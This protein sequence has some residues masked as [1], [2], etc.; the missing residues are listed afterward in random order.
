MPDAETRVGELSIEAIA[1]YQWHPWQAGF[2]LQPWVTVARPLARSADPV[3]GDHAYQA[4]FLQL[5]ATVNLGWE[6]AL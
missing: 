6:I 2:Y 3:V 5:F 4:M 1:G